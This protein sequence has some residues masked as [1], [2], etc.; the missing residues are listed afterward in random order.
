MVLTVQKRPRANIIAVRNRETWIIIIIIIIIII[1]RLN[2]TSQY[3]GRCEE[4]KNTR[5]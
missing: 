5:Y 2:R 1:P 3:A 4:Q